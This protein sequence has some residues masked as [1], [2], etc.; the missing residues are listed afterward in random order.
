MDNPEKLAA[1]G[2]Q[3]E[4]KHTTICVGYQYTQTKHK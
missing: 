2:K 4:E 3:Y 1:W